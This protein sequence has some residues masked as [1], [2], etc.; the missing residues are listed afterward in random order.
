MIVSLIAL[1]PLPPFL[2]DQSHHQFADQRELFGIPNFW[3]VASNLPFIA[4]GAQ[5][6]RGR[7]LARWRFFEVLD[8][9][10]HNGLH[11][12]DYIGVRN[13][14]VPSEC[15]SS[16]QPIQTGRGAS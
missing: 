14:P 2:Q 9:C 7:L 1:L 6:E 11:C 5:V 13:H 4:V 15:S 10:P 8:L 12:I 3:N 16:C